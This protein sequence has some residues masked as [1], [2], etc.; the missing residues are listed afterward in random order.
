MKLDVKQRYIDAINKIYNK[1]I[2][3]EQ[4]IRE[5]TLLSNSHYSYTLQDV[6]SMIERNSQAKLQNIINSKLRI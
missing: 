6:H 1:K 2:S 4:L 5:K 3:D